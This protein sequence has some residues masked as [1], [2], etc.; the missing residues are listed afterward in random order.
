MNKITQF[1]K[2]DKI[3][4][5]SYIVLLIGWL[6]ILLDTDRRAYITSYTD[7]LPLIFIIPVILLVLQILF[8]NRILWTII[9]I[10]IIAYTLWTLFKMF[11]YIV[12]DQHREYTHAIEWNAAT[13]FRFGLVTLILIAINWFVFKLKPIKK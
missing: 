12:V 5:R 11:T 9:L 2:Q 10:C 13:V 1:L 7:Y 8:N 3:Q 6:F 4:R